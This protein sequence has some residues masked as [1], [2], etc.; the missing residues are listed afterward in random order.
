MV[1]PAVAS[2]EL[3]AGLLESER[4]CICLL[5]AALRALRLP[6]FADPLLPGSA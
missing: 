2:S 5:T 6:E 1:W 3:G 4:R